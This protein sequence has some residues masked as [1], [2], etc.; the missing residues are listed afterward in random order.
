MANVM[1]ALDN[2]HLHRPG[3]GTSPADE[4]AWHLE[5]AAVL[6]LLWQTD[7]ADAARARAA[8]LA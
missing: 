2:L 8:R 7:D 6:D 5:R 1:I 4:A 3:P